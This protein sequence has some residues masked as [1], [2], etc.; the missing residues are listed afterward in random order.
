MK[1]QR[2]LDLNAFFY[3][4]RKIPYVI[5]KLNDN[6]PIYNKGQDIDIFCYDKGQFVQKLF[7]VGNIYV[8]KG[9]EMKVTD[10]GKE[11]SYIDFIFKNEL[12]FRFD[13]CQELPFFKNIKIKNYYI[14]S[15]IE[16]ANTIRG[17]FGHKPY[18][19]YVPSKIDDLLLRYIE[20]IEYYQLR[21]DKVKHLNYIMKTIK[22]DP[23]RICFL[24]K[25]H[26][27]TDFPHNSS[28]NSREN[29]LPHIINFIKINYRK[30]RRYCPF[31]KL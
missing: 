17:R 7:E 31:I 15:V 10:M 26:L 6:F 12:H 27:Y 2:L 30:I 20:Y 3:N 5:I 16:N 8:N 21:P 18:L 1:K 9:F 22:E 25:L 29:L 23:E 13:V 24:D 4:V 19:I 28:I 14:Y 11:H